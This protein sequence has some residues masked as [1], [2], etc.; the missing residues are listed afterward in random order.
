MPRSQAIENRAVLSE[1]SFGY[2][3]LIF[4]CEYVLQIQFS[5]SDKRWFCESLERKRNAIAHGEEA[6]ID[7]IQDCVKWHEDTIK[8]MDDL[9]DAILLG[10]PT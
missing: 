5:Y 2:K 6:Y 9:K 3:A 7:D 8:F 1:R 4:F 10:A